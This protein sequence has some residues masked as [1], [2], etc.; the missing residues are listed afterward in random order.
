MKYLFK[1]DTLLATICVFFLMGILSF[2][3]VNIH[4]L[5]PL[6]LALTD[7]HFND[8]SFAAHKS[9]KANALE[10]KIVVVNISNGDRSKIAKLITKLSTFKAKAIGLDVLFLSAKD[11]ASDAELA[12]SIKNTPNI[13]LSDRFEETPSLHY[14]QGF[15]SRYAPQ[16][17]YVNFVGENRG[18]IRHFSPFEEFNGSAYSSFA[19]AIVK[20][21]DKERF[22]QLEKRKNEV[23]LINYKRKEEQFIIINDS[24]IVNN[25]VDSMLSMLLTNKVG[26]VGYVN[27]DPFN[28]EDKH[29]T[30]L[31]E[32]FVGKSIPDMNGVIIHAN[33]LSMLLNND[34]ITETPAWINWGIGFFL[35]WLFTAI[36]LKYYIERQ[37]WF[38]MVSKL[39]Q[40]LLIIL[41]IYIGIIFTRYFGVAINFTATIVAIALSVDTLCFV[42]SF[43]LWTHRKF[44]IST[45]FSTQHHQK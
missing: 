38:S 26:L 43:A 11:P 31:N 34:Y 41:F 8:L 17:G 23:E 35:C 9:N 20:L 45:I 15:F 28:I 2:I 21:A 18:V 32:K 6:K 39:L 12:Q 10:N 24:D 37:I 40:L 4:I 29:F 16:S 44:S 19:A 33:I 14:Q 36:V 3:P 1:K 27:T 5:N 13:I 7:I 30:P 25:R 42:E 22:A